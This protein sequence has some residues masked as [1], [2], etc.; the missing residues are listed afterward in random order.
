ME[1]G[2][3]DI[4]LYVT[5]LMLRTEDLQLERGI[6]A[7]AVADVGFESRSIVPCYEDVVTQAVNAAMPIVQGH[8][9]EYNLLIVGTESSFDF[10]KPISGY[11]HKYLNLPTACSNFEIK[12][13]CYSGT[14]ALKMACSWVKQQPGDQKALVVMSDIGRAHF[15]DSGEVTVGSGA[16]ALS[17]SKN[18]RILSLNLLSGCAAQEVFDVARPTNIFEHADAVL[19]LSSFLD[20]AEMSWDDFSKQHK[21]DDIQKYFSYMLFHT[22]LLSL[23]K[24]AHAAIMEQ[25][26]ELDR[27]AID[28][29]FAQRVLPALRFNAFTG[30]L[31]SASVYAALLGLLT[32]L[33]TV[34]QQPIALFSYGSGACA[35]FFEAYIGKD[36]S[37]IVKAKNIESM[38]KNR[39]RLDIPTYEKL[40]NEQKNIAVAKNYD[41]DFNQV[42]KVYQDYYA[43]KKKLVLEKIQQYHRQYKFS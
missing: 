8:E 29:D 33:K 34:P 31:F 5:P 30:N 3:N 7:K 22:P 9:K 35:E 12:H 38:L 17:V 26:S 19:S 4:N 27:D 16:V 21:V 42:G 39:Y 25:A 23:V 32:D 13:A 37:K 20:L 24:K 2:I 1:T 18:P 10:G 14:A 6:T 36:A 11:V 28:K 43:G 15:G 40:I 41:P